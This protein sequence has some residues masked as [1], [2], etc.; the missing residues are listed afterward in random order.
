MRYPL[1]CLVCEI[2]IDIDEKKW[3]IA[4]TYCKV[5]TVHFPK[6]ETKN[7]NLSGYKV[8]HM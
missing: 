4:V 5:L 7:K 8:P 1:G 2:N 6:T 3:K